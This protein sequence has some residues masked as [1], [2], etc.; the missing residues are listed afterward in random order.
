MTN[1][2][3]PRCC[4]CGRTNFLCSD[5][6]SELKPHEVVRAEFRAHGISITRWAH[7]HR[8]HPNSVYEVI[9]GRKKCV[10]GDAHAAAVLLRLKDGDITEFLNLPSSGLGQQ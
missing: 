8:V 6:T 5:L 10:R 3:S 7:D 4:I 9:K 1:Q 2:S